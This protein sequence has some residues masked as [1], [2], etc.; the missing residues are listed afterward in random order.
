[1]TWWLIGGYVL[2]AA[3]TVFVIIAAMFATG[4]EPDEEDVVPV[5]LAALFWPITVVFFGVVGAAVGIYSAA[6]ALGTKI[7][8][9]KR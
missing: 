6:R 3:V 8:E 5:G 4:G 1:M 9:R 2:G 7:R